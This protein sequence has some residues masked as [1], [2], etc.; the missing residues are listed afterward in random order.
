MRVEIA[1]VNSRGIGPK[2][3]QITATSGIQLLLHSTIQ[4][5]L[6][7]YDCARTDRCFEFGV[8]SFPQKGFHRVDG[9]PGALH[10]VPLK[11]GDSMQWVIAVATAVLA[12]VALLGYLRDLK[13]HR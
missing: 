5:H 4:I 9:T 8:Y 12:V 6:M 13:V 2:V 3:S 7:C 1:P 11:K 10:R